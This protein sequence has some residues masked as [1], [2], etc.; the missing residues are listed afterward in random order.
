MDGMRP[1]HLW[2]IWDFFT[3]GAFM[4]LN[5]VVFTQRRQMTPSWLDKGFLP[6]NVMACKQVLVL[7]G[8]TYPNRLW[9]IWDLFTLVA[10]MSLDQAAKC[11]PFFR[12]GATQVQ[13]LCQRAWCHEGTE[14]RGGASV[15]LPWLVCLQASRM[16]GG[17]IPFSAFLHAEVVPLHLSTLTTVV[18]MLGPCVYVMAF[19]RKMQPKSE[20]WN[21]RRS[22]RIC[23]KTFFLV[24]ILLVV[25]CPLSVWMLFRTP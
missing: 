25:T 12:P 8:V 5:Q 15:D 1:I 11:I 7:R 22:K 6:L 10:F 20:G 23:S 21:S 24:Q 13:L 18:A 17:N 14:T 3:L 19:V 2:C 9:C 4:S 16:H